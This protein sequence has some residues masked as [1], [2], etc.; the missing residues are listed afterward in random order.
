M[1]RAWVSI[2][3]KSSRR[4]NSSHYPR[5][6]RE[7]AFLLYRIGLEFPLGSLSSDFP[8][9]L[10]LKCQL[11]ASCFL[12][13]DPASNPDF[14]LF[15]SISESL[16]F[17]GPSSTAILVTKSPFFSLRLSASAPTSGLVRREIALSPILR[18]FD[19]ATGL[20]VSVRVRQAKQGQTARTERVG[21][22]GLSLKALLLCLGF[23]LLGQVSA[24][25]SKSLITRTELA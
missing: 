15:K 12:F 3:R 20:I 7:I 4:R 18:G 6:V 25:L 24:L 19:V 16:T 8:L 17:L 21:V 1:A 10:L 13:L 9:C 11:L 5:E 14:L 23:L 2:Q 22:S